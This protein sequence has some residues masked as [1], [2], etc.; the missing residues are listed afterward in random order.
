VTCFSRAVL[1][2]AATAALG[3]A[4]ADSAPEEGPKAGPGVEVIRLET[5]PIH[6]APGDEVYR[7]QYFP[8]AGHERWVDQ[9]AVPQTTGLHHLF[10]IRMKDDGTL[11]AEPAKCP[12]DL[13]SGSAPMFPAVRGGAF[14]LPAGVAFGIAADEGL[15]LQMHLLDTG[16]EPLDVE[17]RWSARVVPADR[18]E[19]PAGMLYF[20]N[21]DI[22][23]PPHEQTTVTKTCSAPADLH[24]F[25]ANGHFHDLAVDYVATV[26]GRRILDLANGEVSRLLDP[27]L[28]VHAGD[29]ITWSCIDDNTGATEVDFGPS[30][31]RNEMCNFAAYAFPVPGSKTFRCE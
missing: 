15:L 5:S 27:P 3:C 31:T 17:V 2:F 4:G 9:I 10:A 7:C 11:P 1:A 24:L 28:P 30:L 20:T 23:L 13:S 8:P 21:R 22:V 6:L 12:R 14:T 26:A 16:A 18:V 19:A 29:P 25:G